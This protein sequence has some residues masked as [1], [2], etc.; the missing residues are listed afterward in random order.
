MNDDDSLPHA[1]VGDDSASGKVG[2]AD[3]GDGS[4][5]L[6]NGTP[7]DGEIPDIDDVM[8]VAVAGGSRDPD[9][10]GTRDEGASEAVGAESHAL[11]VIPQDASDDVILRYMERWLRVAGP[12]VGLR[13]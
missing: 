10:S 3:K 13:L 1:A 7:T 4:R 12:V 11:W 6:S 2:P 5:S 9:G 8:V